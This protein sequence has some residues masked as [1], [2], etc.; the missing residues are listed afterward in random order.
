MWG[1]STFLLVLSLLLVKT[2]LF[3]VVLPPWQ[4]PDEPFHLKMA[5]VFADSEGDPQEFDTDMAASLQR[6]RFR[7]LT[8]YTQNDNAVPGSDRDKLRGYYAILGL[9]IGFFQGAGLLGNMFLGR[10]LSAACYL[11][12]VG[13]VYL[14][15]RKMFADSEGYWVSLGVLS[16]VAFQPQYSFFSVTLNSDNLISLLLTVIL[17]GMVWTASRDSDT[18]GPGIR[19]YWPWIISILAM[20][21]A[22]LV[23][24]TGMVGLIFFCLS[25]PIVTLGRRRSFIKA[26]SFLVA[27]LVLIGLFVF[28]FAPVQEETDQFVNDFSITFHGAAGDIEVTYQAFDIDL[29]HEVAILLN[30]KQVGYVQRTNDSEWGAT[31]SL[32]LSDRLV[33]DDVNN[34]LTFDNLRNPPRRVKWGIRRIHIGDILRVEAPHGNIPRSKRF[35]GLSSEKIRR[36]ERELEPTTAAKWSTR[37]RDAARSGLVKIRDV[38]DVPPHLIARF[39]LVQFVSFWFSLGWMIYK[40]SLGW[41]ALFGF[42]SLLSLAGLIRLIYAKLRQSGFECIN[43]KVLIL[44]FLLI[45]ISQAAMIVAYGPSATS[46]VDVA[47]GRCRFMEIAAVSVLIP[48]GL[49]TLAPARIRN[50]VM[51]AF[52]CFMVFLNMIS[53]FQYMIP[54]FYL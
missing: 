2:L 35:E 44:L 16:F 24:R 23:K 18:S 40:M 52:V 10:L 8:D 3:L 14:I 49:W 34:I 36:A 37:V 1:R 7:E 11:V 43:A 31:H 38:F 21:C 45:G 51:K 12:I 47:M 32:V 48:L 20:L 4:G 17:C 22:L 28:F 26:G 25:I 39:F 46:S 27:S 5:Y 6:H 53:V 42:V 29:E 41:Y 13:L 19:K 50:T 30:G 33:R 9:L 15:S 54:I